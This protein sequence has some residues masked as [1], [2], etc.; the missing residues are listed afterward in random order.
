MS[1]AIT[2]RLHVPDVVKTPAWY[3]T[4]RLRDPRH[5]PDADRYR[6]DDTDALFD[7]LRSEV[8]V[9]VAELI[10]HCRANLA[11]YKVP[12]EIEVRDTLP[13]SAVGKI[14][15]RVMKNR[16]D[17]SY[18]HL[19]AAADDQAVKTLQSRGV[20]QQKVDTVPEGVRLTCYIPR[21]PEGGLRA[22]EV[23]AADY[24]SAAQTMLQQLE[25]K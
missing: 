19:A 23:T 2:P 20:L 22:L 6:H 10:A 14:L 24:I 5:R 15:Y 8:D 16:N 17:S 3:E 7:H 11:E 25:Q 12:R 21:G 1:A 13:M 18:F 9:T 4:P